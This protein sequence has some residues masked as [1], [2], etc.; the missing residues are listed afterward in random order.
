VTRSELELG[1][2]GIGVVYLVIDKQVAGEVFAVKVLKEGLVTEALSLLRKEVRKTRKL[3]H[4]NI[5]DVH[6]VNVDGSRLYVL[7]RM[8]CTCK[9]GRA[10]TKA[11]SA[12]IKVP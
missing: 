2:G 8:T 10:S 1:E 11:T 7:Q 3:S 4:P 5:L 9:A 12:D 6:S